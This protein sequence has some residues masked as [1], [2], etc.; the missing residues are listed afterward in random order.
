[1]LQLTKNLAALAKLAAKNSSWRYGLSAL[2]VQETVVGYQ[3]VASDGRRMAVVTGPPPSEPLPRCL[4]PA[5]RCE[6]LVPAADWAR[7]LKSARQPAYTESTA[8]VLA[9]ID[10]R[11]I[12]FF[13]VGDN[14]RHTVALEEGRYPDVERLAREQRSVFRVDV[15]AR[16][17][18]ELLLVAAEF[19]PE[20][21][22]R[23]TLH[24]Q[25]KDKVL[26]VT[27]ANAEGQKFQAA[28]MPLSA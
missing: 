1:M 18:A 9:T 20:D 8:D 4:P 15:D 14:S 19:A 28:L 25:G 5:T 17:L 23:V 13:V 6:A 22:F 24:F 16:Q 27:T 21:S 10:Q 26:L 7:I 12:H 2:R 3:I 11:Q